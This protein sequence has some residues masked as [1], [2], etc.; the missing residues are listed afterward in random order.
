MQKLK[1]VIF[2]LLIFHFS[3]LISLKSASICKNMI[4][5]PIDSIFQHVY[6]T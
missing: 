1:T 6:F 5:Q 2:N 4:C 3:M